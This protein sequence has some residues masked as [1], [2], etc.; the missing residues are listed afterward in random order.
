MTTMN[1]ERHEASNMRQ[2]QAEDCDQETC[3]PTR[4]ACKQSNAKQ[5]QGEVQSTAARAELAAIKGQEPNG[6]RLVPTEPTAEM[7]AAAWAAPIPAVWLDSISARDNLV[8]I[9]KYRAML[10]AAPSM[11][12]ARV[13]SVGKHAHLYECTG[14]GGMYLEKVSQC[15]CMPDVQQFNEWI[16]YPK[17]SAPAGEREAPA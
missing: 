13:A 17:Q 1:E 2:D 4:C 12:D 15:D 5:D 6:W 7:L 14:C 3:E 10:A 8:Q 16:A 11:P 9:T